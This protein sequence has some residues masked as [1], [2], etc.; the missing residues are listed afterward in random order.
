[1][2]AK[3]EWSQVIRPQSH[4]FDI[5]L[6]EL[7]RYRDLLTLFIWRDFVAMYKQTILG[8]LWYLI[9]PV[10]TTVVFTI[11]FGNIAQISTDGLPQ[12]LFY[13]AGITA[14]NYFA[15]CW[16]TTGDVFK[17]N[18]NIFG[19]VYFPRIVTPISIVISNLIKFSI[20]I[21]IFIAFYLYFYFS[22]AD[23]KPTIAL[24]IIPVL[25]LIMAGL[26]LGFGMIVSSLT[27]KYRDLN[28]LLSF[29]IQLM[30]YGTTVIYPLST[31]PDE[32]VN[33]ILANPM[34]G[35]I[36]SFRYATMGVGQFS[37]G[38]LAYSFGFMVIILTIGIVIFNRTEKNFMDTI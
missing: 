28:F 24:L 10:M 3:E 1:M 23:I 21:L 13:L 18:E 11:V 27:T 35:I 29:V 22:G 30:M 33:I 36:E 19:K 38:M 7:W 14:W 37:W 6:R 17:K 15:E 8:P 26:G 2:A 5:N 32:Y 12:M 25:V 34:S 31:I 4:L 16:K 9:Q 20:Q